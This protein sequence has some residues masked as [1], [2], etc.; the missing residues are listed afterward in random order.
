MMKYTTY[1][2]LIVAMLVTA[3]CAT[4]DYLVPRTERSTWKPVQNSQMADAKEVPPPKILP[5]THLAAGLLFEGQG[6]YEKAVIQYRKAIAVSHD[7]VEAYHR[8]G[9][10]LSRIGRHA[11]AVEAFRR[12]VELKPAHM[13]YRNNLGFELMLLQRWAEAE[14]E[15]RE[16]IELAPKFERAHV[17][18]GVVLARQGKFEEALHAFMRI[19]PDSDAYY[20]LGLMYRGQKRYEE[21]AEAFRRVIQLDPQ[22]TAAAAQLE[23][24]APFIEE[25]PVIVATIFADSGSDGSTAPVDES[26]FFEET[27]LT[28]VQPVYSIAA[29]PVIF[30]PYTASFSTPLDSLDALAR[31]DRSEAQMTGYPEPGSSYANDS[32]LA[33]RSTVPTW[34]VTIT[35]D[36][37]NDVFDS[38]TL[39]V[40][41]HGGGVEP[42]TSFTGTPYDDVQ[43]NAPYKKASQEPLGAFEYFQSGFRSASPSTA[44]GGAAA[45]RLT[46]ELRQAQAIAMNEMACWDDLIAQTY[47]R[48]E[49]NMSVNPDFLIGTTGFLEGEAWMMGAVYDCPVTQ[50]VDTWT[51]DSV[52]PSRKDDIRTRS[53]GFPHG[54]QR[55]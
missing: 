33:V 45:H 39:G 11:E 30:D 55:D 36:L 18:L 14:R 51:V 22:F 4:S 49:P 32:D 21:A 29:E 23:Q 3:G 6:Q 27:D 9:L 41:T 15:L 8:L 53:F 24:I 46:T 31:F 42:V 7:Y 26:I 44:Q 5:E 19:L 43:A 28:T 1:K 38:R 13:V 50:E 20:N 17:N 40:G 35:D 2:T 47:R 34:D 37:L 54:P 25:S 16:S 10:V 12:A 52:E 48:H